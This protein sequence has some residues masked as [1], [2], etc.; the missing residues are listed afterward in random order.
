MDFI[1]HRNILA[2]SNLTY[3]TVTFMFHLCVWTT[4]KLVFP[5]K[6]DNGLYSVKIL[7]FP[8]QKIQNLNKF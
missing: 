3:L 5:S 1:Y 7:L 2:Q 8:V 4:E 6:E